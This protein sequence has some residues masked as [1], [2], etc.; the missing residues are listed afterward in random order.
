MARG[1]F[2][3]NFKVAAGPS[4]S[5]SRGWARSGQV[6]SG[7][8]RVWG[9]QAAL[10]ISLL[11]MH[12]SSALMAAAGREQ[13]E[14]AKKMA[15]KTLWLVRHLTRKRKGRAEAGRGRPSGKQLFELQLSRHLAQGIG[16][17]GLLS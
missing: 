14:Q 11:A 7:L 8:G 13:K 16:L 6:R 5:P 2:S 4:P 9:S 1:M 10:S 3:L 15:K 12:N 17:V